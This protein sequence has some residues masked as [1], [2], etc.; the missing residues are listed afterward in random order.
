[1]ERTI[2]GENNYDWLDSD[3]YENPSVPLDMQMGTGQ[4]NAWRAISAV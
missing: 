2:L 1:M 4:I 3:A